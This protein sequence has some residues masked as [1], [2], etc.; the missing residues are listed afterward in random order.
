MA[1]PMVINLR[2]VVT[3]NSD[4]VYP[5]IYMKLI[6]SFLYLVNTRKNMFFVPNTLNQFMVD[7]NQGNWITT[8]HVLG[9]MRGTMEYG[10]RYMGGDGVDL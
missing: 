3:S 2:K 6:R 7:P 9:Y 5:R 1:T 8:K 4:L 10:L